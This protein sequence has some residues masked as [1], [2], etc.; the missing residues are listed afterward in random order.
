MRG[1]KI[2]IDELLDVLVLT[3]NEADVLEFLADSYLDEHKGDRQT[4]GSK[5]RE[6]YGRKVVARLAKFL[7][8]RKRCGVV[9]PEDSTGDRPLCHLLPHG[10]KNHRSLDIHSMRVLRWDGSKFEEYIE[11]LKGHGAKVTRS[12]RAP[13]R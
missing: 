13:R 8:I 6:A 1:V 10:N 4:L 7:D 11:D 3:H 9:G 12:K 2:S 5:A